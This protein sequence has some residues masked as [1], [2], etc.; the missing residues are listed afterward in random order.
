[1][2]N[3]AAMSVEE[4]GQVANVSRE[5]LARFEAYEDLLQQWQQKINLVS[6]T[7]L[8]DVWRRHFLDSV[9]LRQWIDPGVPTLDMGSGAGFPG[10]VLSIAQDAPIVLAECDSRK[11]AFLREVRRVTQ[12]PAEVHDGR[13]E[14]I[15]PAAGF[16]LIVARALAPV[17]RLLELARPLLGKDGYCIFMKGAQVDQELDEAA[18]TWTMDLKRHPSVAD[19][20]GVILEI[21]N[22]D[23]VL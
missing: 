9:Q 23:R 20:R 13:V 5:T 22:P 6:R 7:T 15:A 16:G 19:P 10:L 3:T 1:M 8:A 2:V 12:A 18:Q 17:S 21:R 11:C 14:A 4:F